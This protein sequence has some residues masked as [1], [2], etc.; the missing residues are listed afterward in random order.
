MRNFEFRLQGGSKLPLAVKRLAMNRTPKVIASTLIAADGINVCG[1]DNMQNNHSGFRFPVS[2]LRKGSGGQAGFTLVE[3]PAVSLRKRVAFTLVELLVVMAIIAILSALLFPAIT[4]ARARAYDADCTS[5]L[6]QIGAALYMYASG[7]GG[8]YFP[9]PASD[10]Y[11]GEV[12]TNTL[13]EYIPASSPVW[14][15]KRYVKEKGI[16]TGVSNSYFYWAW[17]MSGPTIYPID[18][19][20]TSNRWTGKGLATNLPGVVLASDP[21]EGAPLTA[22]P[23]M[24]YHAGSSLSAPLAKPGTIVVITGGSTFRISPTK[25]IVR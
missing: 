15:C 11:G 16:G 24:Q 21:F 6:K 2:H 22:T 14:T 23:D 10:S 17:D 20:A 3:L 1:K 9:K 8:G 19:S 5:N 4:A 12:L 18:S 25:G 7:P 13:T